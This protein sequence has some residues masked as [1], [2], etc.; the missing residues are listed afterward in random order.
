MEKL[1]WKTEKR[2]VS[3]LV[4][5]DQNPRTMSKKQAEDLRRSVE[6]FDLVEIPVINTDNCVLAGHQ[7]L[8]ILKLLGRGDEEID[9]RV[10]SRL[11]TEEE[12]KEYNLRS[13]QNRASFDYEMLANRY[14]LPKLL[15]VGFTEIQ[16]GI[17]GGPTKKMC[18]KC[19]KKVVK[20]KDVCVC[21]F[22]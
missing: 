20:L 11:L 21:D 17:F 7:R 5:W 15:G 12:F 4:P 9:I 19:L 22:P 14:E 13:N 1:S 18:E 6:K 10:P 3:E 2:K 16:L 8:A